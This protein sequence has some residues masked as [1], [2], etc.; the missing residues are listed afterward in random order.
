MYLEYH[1]SSFKQ[2]ISIPDTDSWS[3]EVC[4][5]QADFFLNRNKIQAF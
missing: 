3:Q 4:N 5:I 2:L 1:L